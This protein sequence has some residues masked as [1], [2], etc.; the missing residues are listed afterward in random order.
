MSVEGATTADTGSGEAKTSQPL[1]EVMLAMDVVDT[2]RRRQRLVER[3]LDAQ[4]RE[5]DLRERL[6]KIYAAQGI[7]VPDHVLD[8]GVAA[9]K[10]ERFVYKPPPQ[11]LSTRLARVYVSRGRWGKWVAGGF[12]VLLGAWLLYYIM[13][14]APRGELPERLES[15]YQSVLEATQSNEAE[16]RAKQL[17]IAGKT[18]LNGGDD[19][20][21]RLALQ[22][23]RELQD[24]L[25]QAYTLQIVSRP[26]ERSGVWR[27]PDANPDARNYYI[28]VEAMGPDGSMLEV[29]VVNEETGRSERVSKWGLRVEEDVFERI[30]KDK[31][32][33]GIIQQREFGVKRSGELQ[34][35]YR[36]PTTG[37][38][39]TRW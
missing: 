25:Q 2:L 26:G 17:Y 28:I 3:E 13:V 34:P 16:S 29:P 33:D 38:A 15:A 18:A 27:V 20:R 6:R 24:T 5:Q 8:E 7:E 21:A 22:S 23:L 35:D 11:S 19:D 12:A 36:I 31:Q 4:G 9:L 10:E 37:A 1:D 39:I 30:A 32:D 14:V